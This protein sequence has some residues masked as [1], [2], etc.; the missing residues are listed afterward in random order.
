MIKGMTGFG[1]AQLTKDKIK[2]HVEIKTLNHRY[3]D[4]NFYLPS[5][6]GSL[7]NKIRQILQ[8]KMER[9]RVTVTVKIT[10][11]AEQNILFNQKIVHKY[12]EQA[13]LV[14]KKFKLKNDLTLSDLINLPGVIETKSDFIGGDILWP[15]LEK[16]IVKVLASVLKMRVSE[17]K[18]IAADLSDK[19]K[20]MTFQIKK[21]QVRAKQILVIKKKQMTEEEFKSFQ[22]SVDVNEEISR[23]LHYVAEVKILLKT[24]IAVGKK[25]DFVAQEMQRETNTIG[26]KLQD[27]IVSSAVLTLK[28]KIEKIREQAS[29]IE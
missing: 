27:K 9:G 4:I 11:K 13:D 15:I 28:S 14:N 29:N 3:F 20:K 10:Q 19:L 8:K 12:L 23:L 25:I 26:S 16:S 2:A 21:I 5:G 1:S 6:F 22:K 17:G 24:T 18:S 7:E